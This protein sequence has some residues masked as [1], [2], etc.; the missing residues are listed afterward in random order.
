MQNFKYIFLLLILSC[1]AQS[2]FRYRDIPAEYEY[3]YKDTPEKRAEVLKNLKNPFFIKTLLPKNYD[4]TGKA[5]YTAI[6]QTALLHNR[7]VVFPKGKFFINKKGLTIPSNTKVYFEENSVL[8]FEKN[9]M[10][11]YEILRIHEVENVQVYYANIVGDRNTH[12]GKDG[13]WGFG[14]SIQDS[15]NVLLYKPIVKDCW[16]DGIFIGSEGKI[17]SQNVTVD[18]GLVDNN[19]RNGVS[20]TSIIGLKLSNLI[21]ANSNGTFPKSGIDFEPSLNWEFMEEVNVNNIVTFNNQEDGLLIVLVNLK[22][23]REK[24]VSINI[25][26]HTDL[27]SKYGMGLMLEKKE[28][29]G[30]LPLG[31]INIQNVNYKY[32]INGDIRNYSLIPDNKIKIMI[33]NL[34]SNN[35]TDRV[36]NSHVVPNNL[37]IKNSGK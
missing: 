27:Y 9:N 2:D 7:E 21:A 20:V 1:H 22:A 23:P 18:G 3:L 28:L 17:K 11:R 6:F 37:T 24:N 10:I 13:E 25:N 26:Q 35:K 5:D 29:P 31:F 14:I 36:F 4:I 16:G 33:S 8:H 30:K 34:K 19:R 15:K 12:T 32:N